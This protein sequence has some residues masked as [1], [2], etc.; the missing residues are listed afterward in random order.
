MQLLCHV[1]NHSGQYLV[2]DIRN[3]SHTDLF[4]IESRFPPFFRKQNGLGTLWVCL[5]TAR[6]NTVAS[7]ARYVRYRELASWVHN[8]NSTEHGGETELLN[9]LHALTH[10]SLRCRPPQMIPI[11]TPRQLLE[12]CLSLQTSLTSLSITAL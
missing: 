5:R 6:V 1:I 10:L 4:L 3:C 8:N 7:Y 9:V 12:L 2:P 11:A